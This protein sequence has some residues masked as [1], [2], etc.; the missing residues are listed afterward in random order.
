MSTATPT[1]TDHLAPTGRITLAIGGMTCASCAAR[2]G[3][4]LGRLTGVT[5]EV[6]YATETA[7]VD[8]PGTI[9]P[10]ELIAAVEQAGYTAR[11]AP[12]F[13]PANPEPFG[14]ESDPGKSLRMRLVVSILLSLP[15]IASSM[16]PAWQFPQWQW[17]S[18]A[19][20]TPVALWGGWPFHSAAW[21]NLWHGSTTMD[22]L[23]SLGVTAAY[24]WSGYVLFFGHA[25]APGHDMPIY[26]ETAAGVT[27]FLLAGR[28]FE[29]RAK[30]RA[31]DSLR[32]VVALGA[33][34]VTVLRGGSPQDIS[35]EQ[36][37]VG[38]RFLVRPGEK[39]ATD[40]IIVD[41]ATAVD[42][43]LLTGESMPVEVGVGDEV[44]GG[45]VNASGRLVVRAT[46]VGR[47][48]H[49]AQMAELVTRAQTGKAQAQRLA[50]R[51]SGIFVPFVLVAASITVVV[52][53]ALGN[54]L[55]T[56][57]TA[58][59]AVLIIACP[60]ALGLATPTALLVGTGRGAALGILVSGPAA[61]ESA[62]RV[63]T[64]VLD[65]TGTL[66]T[67][68]VTVHD[69][70]AAD[71]DHVL[72]LAGA[73]E[74]ASEHPV[75]RAIAA[76]A[77]T[78]IGDLPPLTDFRNIPGCGV[79][80]TIA[81]G[82]VRAGRP[83][84][85]SENLPPQFAAAV[86][87]ARETGKTPVV[88]SHND[89]VLGVFLVADTLAAHSARAVADLEKLGLHP[90]MLTGDHLPAAQAIAEQVG[91]TDVIADVLPQ[92]KAAVIRRLQDQG[93]T[94][95]MIGDGTNDAAALATADL[96]LALGSGTDIAMRA[97][98][99]TL[100]RSDLTAA[101]DA[102][103]LSRR[104]L[105]TIKT[106]LIWAFTYNIAAIPLAATGLLD[107]M[108]AGAAMALSSVFVVTNSLRLR[109]F[110]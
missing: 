83:A 50:D 59:V 6:N 63:D 69:L 16:V 101:V 106:N 87:T 91:I 85:I 38:D 52:W 5:A 31:T 36:L 107:P 65:K 41:G 51:I 75:G 48:T 60:C 110:Q 12:D 81:G 18:L 82:T 20:A 96:G 84:W 40:G 64:V 37:A 76:H 56:A 10:D 79:Q 49:L 19:L 68:H 55:V 46:R 13:S 70:V 104:T 21:R 72:K 86:A 2:I 71:P 17:V 66:T 109:R 94:V 73:L 98:D 33:K 99:V 54:S 28:Y 88:L 93:H 47:D 42:T 26:L 34:N 32:A 39:I 44:V 67:G 100:V 53:L 108:I 22:T 102:L 1:P 3:K 105:R 7:Q 11:V 57:F 9:G 45:C 15:V 97:S 27:T 62:K 4:K 92:D 35:L 25:S 78:Q 24:T 103:R 14:P 89:E 95:A 30:H 80:G 77:R 90:I 58:G 23:V 29:T 43:S 74:S 8:Y 61:L